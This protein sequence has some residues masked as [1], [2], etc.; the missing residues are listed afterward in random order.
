MAI[1]T[2]EQMRDS[3]PAELKGASDAQLVTAYAENQGLDVFDVAEYYG[4]ETGRDK[5]IMGAAL[6]SA[7]DELQGLGISVGAGLADAVG[8]DSASEYLRGAAE[9]QGYEAYLAGKPEYSRIEDQ[10]SLADYA[11]YGL[12]NVTKG[13]PMIAGIAAAQYIPGAGQ[14]AGALGLS[15]LGAMAPRV[16]GGGGIRQG[17]SVA[18][19]KEALARGESLGASYLAGTTVGYGGLYQESAADGDPDPYAALALAPI[20]GLAETLVPGAVKGLRG[21][22]ARY[23]GGALK[24]SAKGGTEGFIAEALTE[25]VQTEL[26][27]SLNESLTDEERNSARLNAMVAGGLTGSV[28]SA[29]GGAIQRKI[30]EPAKVEVNELGESDLTAA[31]VVEPE[32]EFTQ[33]P[34]ES[35]Y[36]PRNAVQFES[37]VKQLAE[38]RRQLALDQEENTEFAYGNGPAG[39]YANTL[40]AEIID[41]GSV[42][43]SRRIGLE[44][45]SIDAQNK[46]DDIDSNIVRLEDSLIWSNDAS[47]KL[48]D[49]Q[50]T[51]N[52]A[53][54]TN[55]VE[56]REEAQKT[57]DS[58]SSRLAQSDVSTQATSK[59][60][61]LRGAL[62]SIQTSEDGSVSLLTPLDEFQTEVLAEADPA[63]FGMV[64]ETKATEEVE[65]D[66]A[67]SEPTEAELDL[68]VATPEADVVVEDTTT[69]VADDET[70]AAPVAEPQAATQ[71]DEDAD[72]ITDEEAAVMDA[73]IQ[74][75]SLFAEVTSNEDTS[76]GRVTI[77]Q[78]ALQGLAV[79]FRSKS[80][81]P[82]AVAR[83]KGVAAIDKELT[84]AE[85]ERMSSIYTAAM[86]VI[87]F[88]NVMY[89]QGKN[90]DVSSSKGG[91]K[92]KDTAK[93]QY[94]KAAENTKNAMDE[95]MRIEGMNGKNMEAVLAVLKVYNESRAKNTADSPKAY[96]GKMAKLG[97][98]Q[99]DFKS[100]RKLDEKM[101]VVLSSAF[102]QWR[103]NTLG[104]YDVVTGSDTRL[105]YAKKDKTA[106]SPLTNADAENGVRGVLDRVA[107]VTGTSSPYAK[108]LASR[109]K[110][111]LDRMEAE[112][113]QVGVEFLENTDRENAQYDPRDNVIYIHKNA[114]QEEIL[115]ESLH[116]TLQWYVYQ[117]PTAAPVTDLLASLDNVI[118]FVDSG[119]LD[120]VAMPPAH[121]QNAKKIVQ[122]LRDMREEGKSDPNRNLD[123]ALEL[124]SY[125]TTLREFRELLKAIDADPS[126]ATADWKAS[127]EGVYAKLVELFNWFLGTSTN[128][129]ANNVLNNTLALLEKART[130]TKPIKMNMG[131]TLYMADLNDVAPLDM[132]GDPVG[133]AF[134]SDK[135]K[136]GIMDSITRSLFLGSGL[137]KAM[138]KTADAVG[139]EMRKFT[140][141]HPNLSASVSKFIAHHNIPTGMSN[142]YK[143]AKEQRNTVYQSLESIVDYMDKN[144]F[145]TT[146]KIL[147]YMDGDKNALDGIQN[148]DKHKMYAD[149]VLN[150]MQGI[151]P[152]LNEDVRAAFE[153]KKFSEYLLFVDDKT[154]ISSS[155]M[156]A[157]ALVEQ[158]GKSG[159]KVPKNDVELNLEL[160]QKDANGDIVLTGDKFYELTVNPLNGDG[161]YT[162]MVSK[163]KYNELNGQLPLTDGTTSVNT[164]VEYDLSRF[165]DKAGS[166][167]FS[168]NVNYKDK[169][170]RA[171]QEQIINAMRNTV[172][173][174]A[175]LY[176][177]QNFFKAFNIQGREHNI[178]FDDVAALKAE[179]PQY[180][181][182]KPMD[183]S[184][185][186]RQG[187]IKGVRDIVRKHGQF[188][189]LP[190]DAR[191]GDM[192]G[193]LI[194]GPAYAA[195]NDMNDR[196]PVINVAAYN[197]AL[198]GFKKMK[199]IYNFGTHITNLASNVSL[200]ML[201]DIP[202]STAVD[203]AKL[204][205]KFERNSNS[206]TKEERQIMTAFMESGARLGSYSSVEVHKIL[207]RAYEDSAIMP[208]NESTMT[209]V[210]AAMNVQI[211]KDSAIGKLAKLGM[212]IDDIATQLYAAED[213]MFRLAS[214]MK[215]VGDKKALNGV[216]TK[217]DLLTAG[218]AARENFLDYDIDA[219]AVKAARQ[220]L[221]P[222]VS[223][224]YAITPVLGRIALH[225]PWKVVNLLASYAMID[226]AASALSGGDDEE[227]RRKGPEKLDERLFGIPF[228]P[229]SYIRMP[230]GDSD[231][232]V[233][234]KLGD[235]IPL[236]STV[237]GLPTEN[238]F[239]GQSWWPQGLQP[240]GPFLT[241]I[242]NTIGGTDPF[243]GDP[244]HD[245]TDDNVD[246][247]WN[248]ATSLYNTFSPP[249]LRSGNIDKVKQAWDGDVN[250][251]GREQDVA[252]LLV[253]NILG[254]KV[255]G[256]NIAQEMA[257]KQFADSALVRD[258]RS[259][260]AKAKREEMRSGSPNF[261]KLDEAVRGLE[262]E[263]LKKRRELLKV[264]E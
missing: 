123:A 147:A 143:V 252:R 65:V 142:I 37:R 131:T 64:T 1:Y 117:N 195:M 213:N 141:K 129:E 238:G 86:K 42:S 172:G 207:D 28:F 220:T 57:F 20:S 47:K 121:K 181:N 55:L 78:Q 255:E 63:L 111:V 76:S 200:M 18:A 101:D 158:I 165:D 135:A 202:F 168:A 126:P 237:K 191:Y 73:K 239:L 34:T 217:E 35:D 128:T 125:G 222:F 210:T 225:Q 109:I 106:L 7:G 3:A 193:K 11:G 235:Y 19:R 226:M 23:S 157:S 127:L 156:S 221:L 151:I 167:V 91:P 94:A 171:K 260:I 102:A 231:N 60:T 27:I 124:V 248:N 146:S 264:E 148:I 189:Q 152:N 211:E 133:D 79:M 155:S 85:G 10:E 38:E 95:L 68:A 161:T 180:E 178:V 257:S 154:T 159:K 77:P 132:A 187:V 83:K 160:F 14:A 122:L 88:G 182:V 82:A 21:S 153:G 176:A 169:L 8:L 243:T 45:E 218:R 199:T 253:A 174:I 145:E 134:K 46:L 70:V 39:E 96:S 251:A 97:L 190:D 261:K 103:N 13:L 120:N 205:H 49:Q 114:S 194:H 2:L 162:L 61:A 250:F 93:R 170:D 185:A 206:L 67:A 32:P 118:D 144:D 62:G 25:G 232:P 72:V 234:Y 242:I 164:K 209:R 84:E 136:Q 51:A 66:L 240:G 215:H 256:Y 43:L 59:L 104:E 204:L 4:M 229:H 138:L 48:T 40:R 246:K 26:E 107:K 6:S 212:S 9:D 245:A 29:G 230:W 214:F 219:V 113:F 71:F 208:G 259:A 56:A 244:L 163:S 115:H 236:N 31:P 137:S 192:A 36:K 116:A 105:N 139:V 263:L 110:P 184:D 44:R 41:G 262:L 69:A 216:I 140:D 149:S 173:G 90:I 188:V 15:R 5:S 119:K 150:T 33:A 58:I 112:G 197:E 53:E 100:G 81:N 89:N 98:R 201:H 92:L 17:A 241:A 179:H 75:M 258:Y 87:K 24:R 177:S 130:D 228:M 50:E 52:V 12:Y 54:L 249:F 198:R 99:G 74:Q 175:G 22:G 196:N 30:E 80:A 183:V 233:Y 254:F 16:L 224:T 108:S 227:E 203:A 247:L 186:K 223:W 166:Y